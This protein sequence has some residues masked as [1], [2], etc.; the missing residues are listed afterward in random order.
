MEGILILFH[1]RILEKFTRNVF[2]GKTSN[3]SDCVQG[4]WEISR[5]LRNERRK[6]GLIIFQEANH[7]L[8]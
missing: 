7:A 2:K 3:L 5:F 8:H 6:T 4:F 1:A